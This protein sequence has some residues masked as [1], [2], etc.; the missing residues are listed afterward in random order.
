MGKASVNRIER[1]AY[2]LTC[3]DIIYLYRFGAILAMHHTVLR[4]AEGYGFVR[5]RIV[6]T[7]M[8][9]RPRSPNT[10]AQAEAQ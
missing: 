10:A 6:W 4:A 9:M 8:A 1:S 3:S 5:I 2:R 7:D